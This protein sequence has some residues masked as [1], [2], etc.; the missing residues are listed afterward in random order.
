MGRYL[1]LDERRKIERK[2]LAR[3]RR[4]R[5]TL[6]KRLFWV[7]VFLLAILLGFKQINAINKDLDYEIE[8]V[9][10]TTQ[11]ASSIDIDDYIEVGMDSSYIKYLNQLN[12]LVNND[13]RVLPVI[14][15]IEKY[16]TDVLDLLISNTE[17]IDFALG[18]L[19]FD[20]KSKTNITLSKPK[21]GEIPLYQQ[22]DKR[23]GYDEYGDNIIAINGCGPTC[24]SMVAV[25]LLKDTS[26]NPKK[27]AQFSETNG[28]YDASGGTLWDLMR[29]GAKSLGLKVT[30]LGSDKEVIINHLKKGH[31]IIA[32]MS[33]GDFTT[34]GHYI[35]ITGIN[36]DEEITVNDPNSI[37]RSNQKW[38]LETVL[39]QVKNLWAFSKA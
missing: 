17:T 29:V 10:D 19:S 14:E 22:W 24:L 33:P 34:S 9:E 26:L 30:E 5:I 16:P 15:N 23:W 7:S 12:D 4:R 11:E 21:D 27:V 28:Y 8:T 37:K 31:P 35:V 32:S 38:D 39:E 13:N 3:R 6:F 18:Y 25:G 36:D 2:K 20:S 1:T